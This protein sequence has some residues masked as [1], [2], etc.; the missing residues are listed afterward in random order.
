ME[1]ANICGELHKLAVEFNTA[2][3]IVNHST[4]KSSTYVAIHALLLTLLFR[5]VD[6]CIPTNTPSSFLSIPICFVCSV[7]FDSFGESD[8]WGSSNFQQSMIPALGDCVAHASATRIVLDRPLRPTLD[9]NGDE[10][11]EAMVTKSHAAPGRGAKFVITK[12]GC[13]DAK[14]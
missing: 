7:F 14:V 5:R 4:T 9:R 10:I 13:R 6:L 12:E 8:D 11:R 2:V 1:V 3:L